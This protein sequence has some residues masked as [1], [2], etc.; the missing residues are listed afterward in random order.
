VLFVVLAATALA[1]TRAD[2]FPWLAA[3]AA[4]AVKCASDAL[5]YRRLRGALPRLREVLAMPVK[6]L[7]V[8]AVWAVGLFRRRVCWRGNELRI[9]EGSRLTACPAAPAPTRS[10]RWLPS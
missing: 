1:A 3:A 4:I 7:A 9:G 10:A 8:A 6:D 5:V 2:G